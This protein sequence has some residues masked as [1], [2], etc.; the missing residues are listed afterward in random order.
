MPISFT[1]IDLFIL[2]LSLVALRWFAKR[3]PLP[4]PPGPKGW[5]LIGNLLDMPND[6]FAKT[7]TEWARMYGSI[8]YANV[9][10]QPL[11]ILSDIEVANELLDKKSAIYS[12]RPVLEMAGELA[13]FKNWTGFLT[14]GPRWKESRKF[15]HHAIGTRE[16]LAEF[17]SLFESA[18][19][20]LMKEALCDPENLERHIRYSAGTIITRI[21]YGYQAEEKDDPIIALAE[22]AMRNFTQLRNPGTHLV[23]FI[24]LLK[25][26]PPWFPGAGF[27]RMASEA[28]QLLQENADKP[29][30]LTMQEM[31]R[32]KAP[33]SLVSKNMKDSSLTEAEKDC[34]KWA[35]SSLYSGG[36]DT[37]VGALSIFFFAMTHYPEVQRKAQ[38]EI[39]R[40]VGSDR[41]PTLADRGK[42]PYISALLNE[43]Y[44][45]RP[46]VS[47][48][49]PHRTT[50]ADTYKG[51]YIPKGTIIVPNLW[52]MTHDPHVYSNP[53]VF[54][55]ERF[56]EKDGKVAE[57]NPRACVFGFGR[58]I[59]PGLQFTDV[60]VWLGI[61]M[62]LSVFQ[63]SK[64]DEESTEAIPY[65]PKASVFTGRPQPFKCRL[66]PRSTKAKELI[67]ELS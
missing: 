8:V 4:L 63:I 6:D 14:Y 45:W 48:A 38:E 23:D 51:Y 22:S 17:S 2:V 56:L 60:T 25:Y 66:N 67:L 28:K 12:D 54:S 7:Y 57:R 64:V 32:G 53:D 59:C 62:A 40:V 10:G 58:R 19:R 36:A 61:A 27:K 33:A 3:A 37:T 52:Q 46:V 42:S 49:F 47:T 21:A 35:A 43:V 15:M 13:G 31:A 41:L 1:V 16:S 29:F 11:V 44:R 65:G 9:A 5:P 34:L 24:P 30:H 20:K 55:P 18:N 50:T 39:D 26:V